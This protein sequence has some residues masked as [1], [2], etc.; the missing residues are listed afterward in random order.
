MGVPTGCHF[1]YS[2]SGE[3]DGE[4][5][6]RVAAGGTIDTAWAAMRHKKTAAPVTRPAV[7]E[8]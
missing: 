8:G 4:T 7:Q 3:K 5:E 6:W 1:R 2:R